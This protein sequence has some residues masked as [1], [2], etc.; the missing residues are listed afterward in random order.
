MSSGARRKLSARVAEE[1][2]FR[3]VLLTPEGG[4]PAGES[5]AADKGVAAQVTKHHARRADVKRM[6]TSIDR[7]NVTSR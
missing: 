2:P 5:V 4:A 1:M 7:T 6:E 3:M